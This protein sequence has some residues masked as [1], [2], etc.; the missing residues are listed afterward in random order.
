MTA[1]R[2]LK[3][4]L[5]ARL[6]AKKIVIGYDQCFGRGRKGNYRFLQMFQ[7]RYGYE[8][9]R[10]SAVQDGGEIISTSRIRSLLH[11]GQIDRVNGLLGHPYFV[12]GTVIRGRARGRKIGFPTINLAIAKSKALPA[13]GVYAGVAL[14]GGQ[15]FTAMINIG[16]NPTFARQQLVVEA[17]LLGFE[18]SLYGEVFRLYV[19]ERLRD[20]R[21]FDGVD[22][23]Q[24]QLA[25]DREQTVS[26][27]LIHKIP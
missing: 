15:K 7:E 9:E 3:D 8:V 12:T 5:K 18:G 22:E 23:L 4:I 16:K 17:H 6:H 27:D 14:W 13:V 2:Y 21:R 20:E 11:T 1:I 24:E 26:L 25:R 10:I 19:L